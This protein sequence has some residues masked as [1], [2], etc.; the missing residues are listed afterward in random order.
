MRNITKPK[1]VLGENQ[2]LQFD[3]TGNALVDLVAQGPDTLLERVGGRAGADRFRR[4]AT[5]AFGA[6]PVVTTQ[7]A[8]FFRDRAK[9]QGLKEQPLMLIAVLHDQ[10]TLAQMQ[11][12]LTVHAGE[13][14]GYRR[15]D[16]LD[17]LDLVRILSW[18]HYFNGRDSRVSDQ[19]RDLFAWAVHSHQFQVEQALK[20]KS[21][22]LAYVDDGSKGVGL[23]DVLGIIRNHEAYPMGADLR[24]E[25]SEYLYP[26]FR[27]HRYGAT[28]VSDLGIAQRRYHVGELPE[29]EVP[30]GIRVEQVLAKGDTAGFMTLVREGRLSP[31]QVKSN[32][33]NIATKLSAEDARAVAGQLPLN[34]FPHELWA[35]GKAFAGI[36]GDPVIGYGWG[37]ARGARKATYT[38]PN[39]HVVTVINAW[40]QRL[41]ETWQDIA[42]RRTLFLADVSGSMSGPLSRNST[43][44]QG[45][46]AAF[47][48]YFAGYV[49]GDR[50]FGTWD[51]EARLFESGRNPGIHDFEGCRFDWN[52]STDIVNSTKTVADWYATNKPQAAP[53]ALV[54]ISDMQFNNCGPGTR[55][56][57][58]DDDVYSP[59]VNAALNYYRDKTGIKPELVFWNVDANTTPAV[60]QGGVL[61]MG[62]YAPANISLCFGAINEAS[63]TQQPL[64]PEA[65]LDWI[66]DH[67]HVGDNI[68]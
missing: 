56:S 49:R 32:L 57:K 23:V 12:I 33:G 65:I 36:D 55:R 2:D 59:A 31:Y 51:D 45:E 8:R 22:D 34:I 68:A 44:S 40:L 54:Y 3:S 64:N 20:Y 67:Y 14:E 46:F 18:H 37:F 43:V 4:L 29:G 53:E 47:M 1:R 48:S 27:G 15:H 24:A 42:Q 66:K 21:R 17:L 61:M 11:S 26:R 5:A 39:K 38:K 6:D 28:P 25:Y 62:G 13:A 52:G 9:G 35:M 19:L 63:E 41:V 60:Q 16:R 50:V 30:R 58:A 10:L 7:I